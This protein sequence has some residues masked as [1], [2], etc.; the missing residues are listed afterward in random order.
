MAAGAL[1]RPSTV[2]RTTPAARTGV[3]SATGSRAMGTTATTAAAT[4]AQVPGPGRSRPMPPT[5]AQAT[6]RRP[7]GRD[8]VASGIDVELAEASFDQVD[9]GR[10]RDLGVIAL[11]GDGQ[12]GVAF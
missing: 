7:R 3:M 4:L 1:T 11:G 10:H 9:Q 5:V 12:F 6:A 2:A 8:G